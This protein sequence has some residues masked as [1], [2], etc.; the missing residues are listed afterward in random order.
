MN[1]LTLL[2][3]RLDEADMEVAIREYRVSDKAAFVELMEELQDYL[4]SL[5]DLK[6]MRRMPEYGE[7]YTERTLQNVAKNNG[8]IYV[9]ETKGRIVGLVVGI[10]HEQT[11]EELLEHVPFKRGVVLELIVA[12]GYRKKGVGT[13]LMERIEGYF[14]QS[15][16]SVA[17]VDVFFPN[18]TAYRLY[19]KLGYRNRDIW[20]TKTLQRVQDNSTR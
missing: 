18:K 4:V 9:A 17:G 19:S 14:R 16:C 8:V 13:L 20:M 6:R 10:I 5:D 12:R 3:R 15:G 2:R 1:R 11:R 7:S